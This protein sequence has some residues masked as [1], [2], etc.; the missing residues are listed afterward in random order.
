MRSS[1][2]LLLVWLGFS[3][4]CSSS[5]T[6]VDG[7]GR[8]GSTGGTS[9]A[10]TGVGGA[11]V[12]G[13]GGFGH[14]GSAVGT[15]GSSGNGGADASLAD[16]ASG[17]AG[18]ATGGAG[19]GATPDGW[20]PAGGASGAGGIG[21]GGGA[22]G[23]LTLFDG[24]LD[25]DAIDAPSLDA[26]VDAPVG[27]VAPLDAQIS[28]APDYIIIAADS[29]AASAA[30]YRAF[31]QASGFHV[32]LAMV[33]DIVG[34]APDAAA[35][36]A[37]MHDYVRARYLA[38]DVNRPMYLLLLG[39]AQASWPGDGS[40]VPA[41]TWQPASGSSVVS[42]NVFADM[43]GDDVPDLAVGRITADS[44]AEADVVRAKVVAYEA[45]HEP[46]QWNRRINVFASTSGMG[47]LVDMAIETIVY[48]ITEA[49]P[50]DY[51]VTMTYARQS[52]PY[53]YIPEQFSDQVYRRI[54]EGALL[55]AYV[56]HGSRDGFAKL[57]WNGSSY[58]ILDTDRLD[59]LA[60]T[61]RSPMLLFIACL[62]GA[63]A[64]SESVS[65][66]ILVQDNAPVAI[67]SSTEVSDPY[68][69]AIF[70][71]EASQA[72]TS[73]RAARVGDAF[74]RAK[75]RLMGNSDGVRQRIESLAGL[76]VSADARDA[77]KHS[78]LH[79]Y[80]LF[81]DPAMAV[82]YVDS[83]QVDVGASS[84]SA[85]AELTITINVRELSVGGEAI[86]TL[87]S[88]RKVILADIAA[89]P[90]DGDANRD[91]VIAKNYQAANDKAAAL[92]TVAAGPS[93]SANQ[94]T[95][96]LTVPA[97]LPAGQYHIKVFAHD[98]AHDYAGSALLTV[99]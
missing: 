79:M 46:G 87:E 88:A 18:D 66:R 13:T 34:S 28:S 98:S 7:G 45:G 25:G 20:P 49:V 67:F 8:S 2:A 92:V 83:A 4:G 69:N 55:V 1:L 43:D 57:D 38:R 52:S 84:V 93:T 85:G 62:T 31:R 97:N 15:G 14:G 58:P 23:A 71:Y 44:D 24:G 5:T 94:L 53:V 40:G 41:G 73:L 54:N 99:K 29:L 32:D 59:K 75:Q 36:S 80:T 78:H 72:F 47:D 60:V 90:T 89:V 37:R 17:G 96:K 76:L 42:D 70:I 10:V 63:F 61:H 12:A 11:V 21:D 35:A 9:G 6:T 95:T 91:T 81:A 74:L 77:L 16:S 64:G 39:D 3:L 30:R 26:A 19:G 48:D 86:V 22:G 82:H 56:G 51:D 65:E 68:A 33:G 50:Y 27:E